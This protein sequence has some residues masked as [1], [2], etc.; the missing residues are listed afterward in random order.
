MWNRLRFAL[1]K[2]LSFAAVRLERGATR[3]QS[4]PTR[5]LRLDH[6]SQLIARETAAGRNSGFIVADGDGMSAL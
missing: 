4:E 6:Y 5:E 1:G 3:L 2:Q